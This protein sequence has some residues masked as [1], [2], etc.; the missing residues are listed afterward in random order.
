[1]LT[2]QN[3]TK[4]NENKL[5]LIHTLK[6][7]KGETLEKTKEW[8]EEKKNLLGKNNLPGKRSGMN[9]TPGPVR[10]AWDLVAE[11]ILNPKIC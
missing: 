6:E 8:K 7:Q 2:Q 9:K 3:N 4:N 1:M 10:A 5:I 11:H